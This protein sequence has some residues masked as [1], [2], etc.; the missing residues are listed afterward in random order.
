[1]YF[2]LCDDVIHWLTDECVCVHRCVFGYRRRVSTYVYICST[3]RNT[4][5]QS[6][7]HSQKSFTFLYH[8]L[9]QTKTKNGN[10][11][12]N[13]HNGADSPKSLQNAANLPNEK[14]IKLKK[15]NH[16]HQHQQRKNITG[17]TEP[18][19]CKHIERQKEGESEK[20]VSASPPQSS[21][22][23]YCGHW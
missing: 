18:K 21:L 6:F 3:E 7:L 5:K 11:P 23:T 8:L 17:R 10:G 4:F 13:T 19:S 22:A 15:I 14:H 1:M 20:N 16:H 2:W 9:F 12:K